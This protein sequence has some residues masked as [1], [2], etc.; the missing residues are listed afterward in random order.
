MLDVDD[1]APA[2]KELLDLLQEGRITAPYAAKETGYS[3]QYVRERL[4]RLVEHKN[5]EKI[6]EGLYELVEDPRNE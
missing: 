4:T 6:H 5:V 3:K 2:D 1:L